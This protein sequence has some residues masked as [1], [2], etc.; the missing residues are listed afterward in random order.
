MN[1]KVSI[2]LICNSLLFAND[3]KIDLMDDIFDLDLEQLQQMK[4][5]SASKT[6]QNLNFTPSKMIIVTKEQIEQRGYKS[7]YSLKHQKKKY[8]WI[9][10]F[11]CI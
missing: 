9:T 8:Y 3:Y 6:E 7:F 5:N 1:K 11:Y 4:V 10:Y 2:F